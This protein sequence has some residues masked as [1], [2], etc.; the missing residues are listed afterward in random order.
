[1]TFQYAFYP[2]FLVPAYLLLVSLEK[3]RLNYDFAESTISK[4]TMSTVC[5][6]DPTR[7]N[8]TTMRDYDEAKKHEMNVVHCGDCGHCSNFNDIEIMKKTKETLTKTSTQCAIRGLFLGDDATEKCLNEKIGFTPSCSTCWS[9]NVRCTRKHCRYTCLKSI[10]MRE[11]NNYNDIQLN[12]CLE[13]DEKLCGP[14]FI[15]CAGANRRR[16]GIESDIKRD[17]KQ[18]QCALV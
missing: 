11:K 5:A 8:F 12:S 15:E 4:Y 18:E 13:C 7:S 16:L 3:E 10:I 1:M 6:I 2:I 17:S 14:A 9:E